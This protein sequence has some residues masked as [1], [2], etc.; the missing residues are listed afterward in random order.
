MTI[1]GQGPLFHHDEDTQTQTT[2]SIPTRRRRRRENAI[3]A[4]YN[5]KHVVV[6]MAA[7]QDLI[8]HCPAADETEPS[9]ISQCALH[10]PSS[11]HDKTSSHPG[12]KSHDINLLL[13]S[14]FVRLLQLIVHR[15]CFF[16]LTGHLIILPHL[17]LPAVAPGRLR[18]LGQH[19]G[20]LLV[21]D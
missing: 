1:T 10:L 20:R 15:L 21:L 4:P 12:S 7:P 18:V 17:W 3:T 2:T 8:L 14:P 6:I 13:N 9:A 16:F 5:A 11:P 19:S